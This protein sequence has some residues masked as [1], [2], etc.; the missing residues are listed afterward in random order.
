MT[1]RHLCWMELF[2]CIMQRFRATSSVS[3][4]FQPPASAPA[5]PA[6][7]SELVQAFAQVSRAF[8]QAGQFLRIHLA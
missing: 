4:I 6:A 5:T 3:V 2:L 7:A 1:G 8:T